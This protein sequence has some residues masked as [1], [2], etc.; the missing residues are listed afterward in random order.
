M[1]GSPFERIRT[2]VVRWYRESVLKQRMERKAPAKIVAKKEVTEKKA[3]ATKSVA[4]P[5]APAQVSAPTSA[6]VAESLADAT[7]FFAAAFFE[8]AVLSAAFLAAVFL[9]PTFVAATFLAVTFVAAFGFALSS[10]PIRNAVRAF[11]RARHAGAGPP[12]AP[13]CPA[14]RITILRSLR[15]TNV[16]SSRGT[17][18]HSGNL[19][20][21]YAINQELTTVLCAGDPGGRTT[22]PGPGNATLR[23][24]VLCCRRRRFGGD[25]SGCPHSHDEVDSRYE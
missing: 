25:Q 9:A 6:A 10:S 17:F 5:E 21:Q 15:P 2:S 8:A 4:P 13:R 23:I 14:H 12:P 19:G 7:F 24:A 11:A 18:V 16:I 20:F 3:A 22:M 1:P